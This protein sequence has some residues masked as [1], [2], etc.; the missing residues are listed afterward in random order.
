M[1]FKYFLSTT[2]VIALS[3]VTNSTPANA[4]DQS[5]LDQ[6]LQTNSCTGIT[7]DLSFAPLD[8]ADLTGA[9]LNGANLE[10][11]RSL[12]FEEAV[13]TYWLYPLSCMVFIELG[14]QNRVNWQS[15][16][17]SAKAPPIYSLKPS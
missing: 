4:Y 16:H 9:D 15:R 13:F 6:L 14:K 17:A 11:H 12:K 2:L 7:C 5:D 1:K 8:D 3:Q 10:T